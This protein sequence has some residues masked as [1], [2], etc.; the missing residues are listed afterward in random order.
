VILAAI[1][2]PPVPMFHVGPLRLSI[3]G[4]FVALGFL[5]GAALAIR[6]LERREGD[7]AGYQS[8]LMWALVGALLGARF[9][10]VPAALVEGGGW[11]AFSPLGGN[12]SILGGFAGGIGAGWWRMRR[13]GMPVLG[14]LDVSA[15]GL[16][17]GTVIG[18]LGCLAIVE[19]LGP[20]T[21]MPWGYAVRPG[22]RLA[23]Q[24]AA[25][26]CTTAEAGLDG[27]C[28]VYHSVGAYDL[29][30]A[31]LLLVVLLAVSSRVTL[32]P[33]Q[34]FALWMAWY[35]LQRFALDSLRIAD[36]SLGPFTW[37]QITGL[38]AGV[39]GLWLMWWLGGRPRD[40]DPGDADLAAATLPRGSVDSESDRPGEA[41][42]AT[43]A[44]KSARQ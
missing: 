29:I 34:L 20:Q 25:L 38:A 11:S 42:A 22:Y 33:G 44:P 43:R 21:S 17:L 23:P 35:G 26:Q 1:S 16:A 18:R 9:L 6:R 3:H 19:H 5:A 27:V 13:L 2:Y 32:R 4:V 7:V 36:A 41:S 10:T 30:G 39:A 8:V 28:G 12:F 37:N 14:T 24:H 15:P 40:P 31:G